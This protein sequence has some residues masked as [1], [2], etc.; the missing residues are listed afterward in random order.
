[1]KDFFKFM[2]ASMLG[3]FLT[4]IIVFFLFFA[5]LMALV[6]FTQPEEVSVNDPSILHLRLNYDIPDR[7]AGLPVQYDW[8]QNTFKRPPGL[9]EILE[10]IE[11]AGRDDRIKGIF[12]ELGEA[13]S[14]MAT[15]KEI[16][17][18]LEKFKGSGKFIYAYGNFILQKGY[19]L[20]TVA[21]KV[22]SNPEGLIEIKG[23]YGE[24]MFIKGLLEKLN[25]E[26]Q[27][28]R[29]G[30]F[31]SAVEPLIQEKMSD[32][33][34]IQTRAYIQS[35][36]NSAVQ[37]MAE[38]RRL[39]VSEINKVADG[40]S[41]MNP[42]SALEN[43]IVDSLIY[44][45]EFL[46]ILA[47][48]IG[49]EHIQ[50]KHLIG[51][52]A[53]Q[54]AA[55]EGSSGK[56][57][58]NKIAV[59]FASG[60]I[61]QGEGSMDRIGSAKLSR[62]IRNLRLDESVKAVVLRVNSPG[63]DGLASDIILREVLLAKQE[64]PVV[65]SMGNLAASGGY[66]IACGADHIVAQPVTLTGSIGVFGLIPNAEGFFNEKLGIT[67]DGIQTN[68]N[69]D[70]VG[71]TKPLPEYQREMLQQEIDR[72]Y[73][74]FVQ[75]VANGRNMSFESVDSIAQ[76]RVWSG[77]DALEIGLVDELGGLE[78]AIEKAADLAALDDYRT[79]E[80]PIEKEPLQQLFEDLFGAMETKIVR[81]YLGPEYRS[82]MYL[83]GITERSG[84]Q[85]RMP[86]EIRVD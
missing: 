43:E 51:L 75:H 24:I 74:T 46:A 15:L 42:V 83:R 28:I 53:Y 73:D 31:K 21:D 82:L 37:A 48:E 26:P 60:D 69:A 72:F 22:Y 11:K 25:I 78:E 23:F 57:S 71:I 16:R 47:D 80:Y 41:A 68:E 14:G 55:V 6:S 56:R 34:R 39:S 65:V 17:Y 27:V 81:Q 84:I 35:L 63:G 64:K 36:W 30:K 9:H 1:M 2:F 85:A 40:L 20:G 66:Y 32:E 70:F 4:S 12:L 76:G 77:I 50:S 10:T 29:H 61:V 8:F 18:A 59:V 38:D 33:N 3:F 52:S 44:Y 54:R 79:A 67:F 13:P 62:T 58:K 7:S 19:Y 49:E 45:D 86:F 5:F